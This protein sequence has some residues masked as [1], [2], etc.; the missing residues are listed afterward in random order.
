M[1][2]KLLNWILM[3]TMSNDDED[4]IDCIKF[5]KL[6]KQEVYVWKEIFQ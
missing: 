2:S 6:Q 5:A 3:K 4:N 1:V